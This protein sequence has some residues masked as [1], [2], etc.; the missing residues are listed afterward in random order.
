MKLLIILGIWAG[1]LNLFKQHQD[2]FKEIKDPHDKT[3]LSI[4]TTII[5]GTY[6]CYQHLEY[7]D[8]KVEKRWGSECS[9]SVPPVFPN[10]IDSRRICDNQLCSKEQETK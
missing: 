4:N 3:H 1:F 7:E 6:Y 9:L 10:N 2:Q 8:V 5:D